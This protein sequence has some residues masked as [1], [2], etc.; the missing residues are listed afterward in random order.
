[1]K[2]LVTAPC[3]GQLSKGCTGTATEDTNLQPDQLT[4]PSLQLYSRTGD[5][6]ET[7]GSSLGVAMPTA[8]LG[9]PKAF[10]EV[11]NKR[12]DRFG[13]GR[14]ETGWLGN[15]LVVHRGTLRRRWWGVVGWDLG[16]VDQFCLGLFK[17]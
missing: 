11:L 8:W 9:C 7:P 6:M 13:R 15:D 16:L 3:S 2:A 5:R 10:F 1:M 14:R 12:H 4:L 17:V